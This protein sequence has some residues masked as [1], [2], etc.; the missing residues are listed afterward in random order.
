M[1][2]GFYAQTGEGDIR[3]PST[4]GEGA[5]RSRSFGDR[6]NPQRGGPTSCGGDG[7]VVSEPPSFAVAKRAVPAPSAGYQGAETMRAGPSDG[8]IARTVS[9]AKSRPQASVPGADCRLALRRPVH[10]GER[11]LCRPVMPSS[12]RCSRSRASRKTTSPYVIRACL[13]SL[14]ARST[15]VRE[16]SRRCCSRL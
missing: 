8:R 14:Y 1:G 5:S 16:R 12:K 9:P 7:L 15:A 4:T 2:P 3:A 11:W 6:V 13:T 10:S